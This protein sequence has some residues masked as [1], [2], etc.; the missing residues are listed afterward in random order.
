VPDSL[1]KVGLAGFADRNPSTL[2]GGEK[3]RL[4]VACLHAIRPDL[5]IL[6]E[7][8]GELDFEWKTRILDLIAEA[9]GT[10]LLMESRWSSLAASRGTSFFLL[11]GGRLNAAASD[12][13]EP[14]FSVAIADAGIR[15]RAP[16]EP[17]RT[18]AKG[19]L[20]AE[21]L[22]FQFDGPAGFA[23]RIDALDLRF[24]ETCALVGRNGSGKSTLGR[25]LC[26]LLRPQA[27]TV[28][29]GGES[30]WRTLA[31][32]ELQARVGYLFQNPDH[33]IY[34]PSVREELSLGLRRQRLERKEIESR[35][36]E[37]AHVFGLPDLGAPPALLSYGAR[38]RLQAATF[39][40]L[41]RDILILDEL[42]SGLSYRE[43]ESLIDALASRGPGIVLITHD[44][45]LATAA[46]D[47][48]LSME[49]GRIM[50]DARSGELDP[51]GY[52]AGPAVMT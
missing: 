15:Q 48:I 28:R 33:Q 11:E 23:L 44:M 36:E 1:R 8:L 30:G 50:G 4:L 7:A 34:L 42:D 31:A 2:S 19:A 51:A 18:S 14:S 22:G 25:I 13:R 52:G 43:V 17:R 6:D 5:W 12:S 20:R 35:V 21:G 41:S 10:A 46:C 40:L 39:F 24:G 16:R 27:G 37:A 38:R 49:E 9:G 3:K 47:R 26:G 32:E 29:I 45:A